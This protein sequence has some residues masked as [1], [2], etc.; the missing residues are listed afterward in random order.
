MD[1][2]KTYR[3]IIK[4]VILKYAQFTPSHGEIRLD[5]IFDETRD[6]YGLMQ[7]GWSQ[8]KRIRGNLIYITLKSEKIYIEYD[9]IE[10]GITNELLHAG[11]PQEN[12]VLAFYSPEM[13]EQ[14]ELA[15]DESDN[16]TYEDKNDLVALSLQYSHEVLTE[17][18]ESN[19][20]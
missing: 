2:Q 11:V 6:R 18:Q 12:I 4:Q 9:G 7:V 17:G 8:G 5:P 15:R 3:E 14:T 1:I 16:W 19:F 10:T 20:C 13:V